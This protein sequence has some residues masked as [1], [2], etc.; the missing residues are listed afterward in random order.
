MKRNEAIDI[1]KFVA[2][3][4]VAHSHMDV[5]YPRYSYICTGGAIGDALFFF[6]SGYTLF[7][8]QWGRFDN[9]YKKRIQRIYPTILAWAVIACA[10][11]GVRR[12]AIDVMLNGGGY[13]ISCIMIFYALIYWVGRFLKNYIRY[14]LLLNMMAIVGVFVFWTEGKTDNMYSSLSV[15]WPLWNFMFML[16]G[17]S[18]SIHEHGGKQSTCRSFGVELLYV[19]LYLAAYYSLLYAAR[20]L[21]VQWLQLVGLVPLTGLVIHL[22]MMLKSETVQNMYHLKGC[23]LVIYCMG[24]LCL[25]VYIV[26]SYLFSSRWNDYFPFNVLGAWVTVFALAYLLKVCGNLVAQTFKAEDY[27]WRKM[28]KL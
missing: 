3:I 1:L 7:L 13:F 20:Q 25:E 17:A 5:L 23:N 26:Q 9:W 6:I 21:H 16:I 2:V 19:V 11:F 12:D 10:I 8:S 24:Q 28:I 27:D 14:I 22:Y 15:M 4:L 18:V